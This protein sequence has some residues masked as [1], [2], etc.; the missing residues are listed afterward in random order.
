MRED[1]DSRK[2][3]QGYVSV[4]ISLC[5]Y[6]RSAKP[7]IYICCQRVGYGWTRNV[8]RIKDLEGAFSGNRVISTPAP[9]RFRTSQRFGGAARVSCPAVAPAE[10]PCFEESFRSG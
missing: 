10:R 8:V 6:P 7:R 5:E 2:V 1:G 4:P 3:P 9:G